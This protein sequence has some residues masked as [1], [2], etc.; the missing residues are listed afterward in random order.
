M[1]WGRYNSQQSGIAIR[2]HLNLIEEKRDKAAARTAMYKRIRISRAYNSH[3][4]PKNFQVG[5]LVLR[6]VEVVRPVRN[7]DHKCEGLYKT[8]EIL[9][10]GA[11]GLQYLNGKLVPRAWN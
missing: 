1:G 9:K 8:I 5:D 3:V 2:V 11:Y 4:H 6:K 10:A 7:L